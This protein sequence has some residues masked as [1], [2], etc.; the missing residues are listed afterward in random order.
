MVEHK[1]AVLEASAPI[2]L[3][4]AAG[5]TFG[6]VRWLK[7]YVHDS[8][9]SWS[10]TWVWLIIATV[11]VAVTLATQSPLSSTPRRRLTWIRSALSAFLYIVVMPLFALLGR[12]SAT[13]L[14][15]WFG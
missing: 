14:L 5:A 15:S 9:L 4:V 12:K 3:G 10:E 7:G 2:L 1:R 6:I 11:T 8:I 13:T